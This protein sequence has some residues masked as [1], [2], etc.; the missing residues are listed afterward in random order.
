MLPTCAFQHRAQGRFGLHFPVHNTRH[1]VA[2]M[3]RRQM[4]LKR[5]EDGERAQQSVPQYRTQG[6]L[7]E[8]R[9]FKEAS[10]MAHAR[11]PASTLAMSDKTAS[12]SETHRLQLLFG[13]YYMW[14]QV[15]AFLFVAIHIPTGYS[16]KAL[17]WEVSPSG[18]MLV[19]AEDS[20]PVIDRQLAG[21]L[22]GSAAVQG[23][24]SDDN[25]LLA[26][27]MRVRDEH[28]EGSAEA[29][30]QSWRRLFVGDSDG[31]RSVQPPYSLAEGQGDVT[32][33]WPL[34][35]WVTVEQLSVLITPDE[36]EVTVTPPPNE[37]S[38]DAPM[39]L[40]RTFWRDPDTGAKQTS[41]P[42]DVGTSAWSLQAASSPGA[43]TRLTVVLAKPPLTMDEIQ[44]R[45]GKR[46]DNRSAGQQTRPADAI[47]DRFFGDDADDFNLEAVVQAMSFAMCGTAFVAPTPAEAY[48][49]AAKHPFWATQ[50]SQ[51]RP[52]TRSHLKLIRQVLDD[53]DTVRRFAQQ[54]CTYHLHQLAHEPGTNQCTGR[55]VAHE[56]LMLCKVLQ[57]VSAQRM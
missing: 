56:I 32:M 17:R 47:G 25:T 30:H 15:G 8:I 55:A 36:L 40:H 18:R 33:E 29:H 46:N 37:K 6:Q 12:G 49:I 54:V 53:G 42:V 4:E 34:P 3:G 19:Q 43:T 24:T 38:V 50:E 20:G 51:L 23:F 5:L 11:A 9:A 13:R 2:Q 57:A 16:D 28:T 22:D 27:I 14:H 26:L 7:K 45:K 1:M 21:H 31:F 48:G 41:Q 39:R 10:A 52:A 44:Y 35:G